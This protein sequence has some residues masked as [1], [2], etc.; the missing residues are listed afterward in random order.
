MD[1]RKRTEG[2]SSSLQS[3]IEDSEGKVSTCHHYIGF[4]NHVR[5]QQQTGPSCGISALNMVQGFLSDKEKGQSVEVHNVDAEKG[6]SIN[7]HCNCTGEMKH[8]DINTTFNSTLDFAINL[9]VT[10]DGEM[11][12]AYN[13]A[14]IAEVYNKVKLNVKE[15]K[16][17]N[18]NM[19]GLNN[20]TDVSEVNAS[21]PPD[22][23]KSIC[24]GYPVLIPYDRSNS[25]T[26][27][28][29]DGRFAHWAVIV[30]IIL[31]STYKDFIPHVDM[32]S[33]KEEVSIGIDIEM[34]DISVGL[35]ID[36]GNQLGDNLRDDLILICMHGMS[37][38]CFLSSYNNLMASNRQLKNSK[39]KFYLASEGLLH[40]RNKILFLSQ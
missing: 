12:C 23:L 5:W 26:P 21:M 6:G 9:G 35:D 3:L 13:L 29:S 27:G 40:L 36:E 18:D 20:S 1:I 19:D 28:Q 7:S 37:E 2:I 4:I 31:P 34:Y 25:F 15:I 33:Y 10:N 8:I 17:L 32:K 39:S 14:Y 38:N 30:G 11:F 16:D 22:I 24:K